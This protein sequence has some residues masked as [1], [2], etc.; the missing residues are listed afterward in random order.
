[1]QAIECKTVDEAVKYLMETVEDLDNLKSMEY[2]DL[3]SLHH[4]FGRNIRNDFGLWGNNAELLE[5]TGEKHP[6]D[7]SMVI[8]QTLWKTLTGKNEDD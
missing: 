4:G 1:M 5:S 2:S 7:A 6:D 8:I 3:I